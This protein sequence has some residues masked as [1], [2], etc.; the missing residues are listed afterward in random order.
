MGVAQARSMGG[1]PRGVR[2]SGIAPHR[3]D[4]RAHGPPDEDR[5]DA[6]EKKPERPT[7]RRVVH[8]PKHTPGAALGQGARDHARGRRRSH[9]VAGDRSGRSRGVRSISGCGRRRG[10]TIRA[11]CGSLNLRV[12]CSMAGSVASRSLLEAPMSPATPRVRSSTYS[13]PP[14]ARWGRRGRAPARR[15]SRA[16][17]RHGALD[18]V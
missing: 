16:S 4:P 2:L 11:S 12:C 15:R 14:A 6:G 8:D 1:G 17:P 7:W 18:R 5:D 13:S 9:I 3:F 10:R